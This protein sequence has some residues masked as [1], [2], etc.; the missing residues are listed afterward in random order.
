MKQIMLDQAL[1]SDS[2]VHKVTGNQLII[3]SSII[4]FYLW[5]YVQH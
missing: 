3:Y 4:K 5:S 1:S 2:Y